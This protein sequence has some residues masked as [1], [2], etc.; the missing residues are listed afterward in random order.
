MGELFAILVCELE[1]TSDL[2]SA[3]FLGSDFL[4]CMRS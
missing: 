2:R 4:L 1:R 3:D